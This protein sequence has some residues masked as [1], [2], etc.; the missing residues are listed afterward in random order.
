MRSPCNCSR[1][2]TRK[3]VWHLRQLDWVQLH[4][5]TFG[6]DLL[7]CPCGGRRRIHAVHT[8]PRAADQRL[9][10]APSRGRTV[11]G[12]VL[13]A[14]TPGS[15]TSDRELLDSTP[16]PAHAI[17]GS[18]PALFAGLKFLFFYARKRVSSCRS[19]RRGAAKR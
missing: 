16:P 7:R 4:L 9:A 15:S 6:T 3:S 19:L 2:G 13:L 17:I 1:R 11:V 14:A 5:H 18:W 12:V 8:A 10:E